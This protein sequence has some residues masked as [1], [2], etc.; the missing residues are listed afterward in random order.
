MENHLNLCRNCSLL[1]WGAARLHSFFIEVSWISTSC[2]VQVFPCWSALVI[3]AKHLL[4]SSA[5]SLHICNSCLCLTQTLNGKARR[6]AGIKYANIKQT[7]T[8]ETSTNILTRSSPTV[9]LGLSVY[10]VL[11][12]GEETIS[13]CSS[14][15]ISN[16]MLGLLSLSC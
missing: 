15:C 6:Q 5:G 2:P 3:T 13:L 1:V 11:M 4:S 8:E 14:R 16:L 10:S 9:F 12:S 7:F